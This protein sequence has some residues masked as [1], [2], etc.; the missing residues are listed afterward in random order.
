MR[1]VSH[2]EIE[3]L[4]YRCDYIAK[5]F[6]NALAERGVPADRMLEECEEF[7]ARIPPIVDNTH[8]LTAPSDEDIPALHPAVPRATYE[9]FAKMI[10]MAVIRHRYGGP[11]DSEA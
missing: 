6:L 1:E 10:C 2:E 8:P 9:S 5:E 7:V 11:A 4:A 3:A